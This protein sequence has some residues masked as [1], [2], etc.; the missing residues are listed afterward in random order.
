MEPLVMHHKEAVNKIQE[1]D[2]LRSLRQL[3]PAK[4]FTLIEMMIAMFILSVSILALLSL[5]VTS[6]QANLQ[7]DVR[8]TAVRL[9]S[10]AAEMLLA[11]D[12]NRIAAGGLTPYDGTNSAL[13]PDYKQ[14]PNPAQ[15]IRNATQTFNVTWTVSP[16]TTDLREIVITVQYTFRGKSYNNTTVIYKHRSV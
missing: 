10:Q 12:F 4:G 15:T 14:Y 13:L 9:S 7:N 8:N 6:I 3:S 16:S 11:Q 2:Y 5:T 1:R